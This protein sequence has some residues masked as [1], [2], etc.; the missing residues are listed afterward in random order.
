MTDINSLAPRRCGSNFKTAISNSLHRLITR[1]LAVKLWMPDD[2]INVKSPVFHVMAWCCQTT[3]RWLSQRWPITISSIASLNNSKIKRYFFLINATVS[4]K[5]YEI[6]SNLFC[7]AK[8]PR[9]NKS[10]L[11]IALH[12]SKIYI[13]CLFTWTHS[14]YRRNYIITKSIFHQDV[15]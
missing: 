7:D 15:L 13:S 14:H 12:N 10:K 3:S 6:A 1:P 11:T 4:E 9:Q 2:H 8:K 5:K